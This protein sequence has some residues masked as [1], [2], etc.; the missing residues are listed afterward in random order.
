MEQIRQDMTANPDKFLKMLRK[1]E[2]ATG[3]KVMAEE[4]YKRPKPTDN[5]KLEP[6]FLWKGQIGCV[7][8]EEFS[9]A[10][11]GPE[12]GERV[13]TLLAQLMPLYDYFSRFCV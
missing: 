4:L 3:R 13:K 9:E 11:F 2:K 1:V 10:T 5:K 6:Y 8:E 12:L 7:A